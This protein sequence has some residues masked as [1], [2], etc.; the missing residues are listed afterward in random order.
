MFGCAYLGFDKPNSPGPLFHLWVENPQVVVDNSKDMRGS[1]GR[2]QRTY[3][4]S[5]LLHHK[6]T[7]AQWGGRGGRVR[8]PVATEK[9]SSAKLMSIS[10]ILLFY[11]LRLV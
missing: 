8:W 7:N 10:Y 6:C 1:C 2:T 5:L 9:L 3:N 11:V 4:E